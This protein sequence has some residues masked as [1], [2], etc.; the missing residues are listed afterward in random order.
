M[1]RFFIYLFP[2]IKEYKL[3][4]FYAMIGTIL[5]AA[6]TSAS[7]Y[8]V[9][10]VL[11]DIFLA[12][13]VNKLQILPFFIVLA[14]FLKGFGV[15]VQIYCMS[16]IGQDI[17]RRLKSLLL[18]KMLTFEMGFFNRY[19]SGELLSRIFSDVLALQGAVSNYL[20]EGVRESLTIIGLVAVVIYQSAELA[21]YGL[22][23]MPMALYPIALIA[24]KM[25]KTSKKM[26][27]KNADLSSKLIEIFNNI[28]MIKANSGEKIEL[29]QF[30]NHNQELF[31]LSM[32]SVRISELT[33]PLMETLGAIAIAVVIFVGG[34]KVI[35]NE[36]TAGE[37]FSFTTALFL[38]YTPFKR[39]SA[40]YSKIQIAFAAGDRIFEML[41][42]NP[43]IQDGSKVLK[44]PIEMISFKN[45]DLFYEEKQALSNINLDIKRGESIA[46]VGNSGGGKSSLVNLLLRL[47][48]ASRGEILINGENIKNFTQKSLR[49]KAA[50]VTQRIF[51]F[52][53]SIARNI[54]YG[55]TIDE[56]RV[57]LALKQA[58]ILDYVE[59][60]PHGI[61][62]ILDEFGANL[63][64]GQR[65]RIAIARA[66]YRDP[67][68]LI[69]DEATSALDNKTEE[70]FREVLSGLL[71]D[72]I[73]II[74]AHRLS[75]VALAKTIYFFYQGRIIASGSQE[76][77]LESCEP[78]KEYYKSV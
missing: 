62:T 28:E 16:Y 64:G 76:Q 77:L 14:Y 60:L 2:Y 20:I 51:I 38:L 74:I 24:R 61:H 49:S 65:Q 35:G 7:A 52:N 73:V 36:L 8:L 54:A 27:E 45:V 5:A 69:L 23:V 67:E 58:R 10:P 37:F 26:Q 72:R 41:E 25:R 32:K 11:D 66:L 1:K 70:E 30:T 34:Y 48:E 21:F 71:E 39:I 22:V 15:Y 19:R 3:Y 47:Y 40:L 13:D 63:S 55:S 29:K 57:K 18:E 59:S 33:S 31:R 68:I 6:A 43:K 44:H 17:I 78:F 53:D 4:F 9:K 46:F 50:I 75:T 42:R 56:S 12:K